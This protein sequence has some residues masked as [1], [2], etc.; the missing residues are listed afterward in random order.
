M[1][2]TTHFDKEIEYDVDASHHVADDYSDQWVSIH[3]NEFIRT[4]D[5]TSIN[6]SITLYISVETAQNLKSALSKLSLS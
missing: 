3:L 2:R 5:G 4:E 1:A 6:S